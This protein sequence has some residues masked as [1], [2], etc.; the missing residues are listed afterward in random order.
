MFLLFYAK[1]MS[2]YVI[3]TAGE[4]GQVRVFDLRSPNA[5]LL[6][7]QEHSRAIHRMRF[8]DIK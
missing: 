2:M 7:Y 1:G 6:A 4:T 8:C 5:V 3:F